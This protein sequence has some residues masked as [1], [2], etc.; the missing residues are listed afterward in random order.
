MAQVTEIL[1]KYHPALIINTAAY[2][3]VDECEDFAERAFPVNALAVRDLALAAKAVG[4]TLVHFST[5]SVFDGDTAP[6]G[7]SIRPDP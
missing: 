6:T 2:H 1:R 7:K 4:A 5:D 3:W